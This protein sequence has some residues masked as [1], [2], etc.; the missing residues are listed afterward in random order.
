[1][2]KEIAPADL[3]KFA[4]TYHRNGIMGH[5]FTACG[6]EYMGIPMRAVVFDAK[7]YAVTSGDLADRWRGDHFINA[8][9]A[10]IAEGVPEAVN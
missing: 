5:S 1:M 9:E 8:I 2:S 7:T 4:F 3:E 6:F 10:R